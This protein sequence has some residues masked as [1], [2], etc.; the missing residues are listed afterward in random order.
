MTLVNIPSIDRK[1]RVLLYLL[2]KIKDTKKRHNLAMVSLCNEFTLQWLHFARLLRYISMA[3]H[4]FKK[5]F[6]KI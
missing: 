1:N 3:V 6:V 2:P 4:L 5:L